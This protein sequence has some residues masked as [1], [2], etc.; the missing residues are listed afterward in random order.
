MYLVKD[1]ILTL[2]EGLEMAEAIIE[3]KN[4]TAFVT[5]HNTGVFVERLNAHEKDGCIRRQQIARRHSKRAD[6]T[7]GEVDARYTGYS[8]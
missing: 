4:N 8:G 2:M 1:G 6:P 7:E 5:A 3:V